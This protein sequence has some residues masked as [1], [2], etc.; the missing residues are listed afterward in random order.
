MQ[1]KQQRHLLSYM[2]IR[3]RKQGIQRVNRS[4]ISQ[5]KNIGDRENCVQMNVAGRVR[6]EQKSGNGQ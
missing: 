6:P 1:M 2:T 4:K 5:T 3:R